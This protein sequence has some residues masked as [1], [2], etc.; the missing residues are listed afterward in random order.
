MSGRRVAFR[1]VGV[2]GPGRHVVNLAQRLPA[3]VYVVRL[4]QDGRSLSARAS[5]V[6]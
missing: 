4:L 5:V 2:L 1:E 3:G 6:R